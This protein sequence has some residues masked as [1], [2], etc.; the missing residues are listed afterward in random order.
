MCNA[1]KKKN[2]CCIIFS[3]TGHPM[4]VEHKCFYS[5]V[6]EIVFNEYV[7]SCYCTNSS[8]TNFCDYFFLRWHF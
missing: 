6:L 5:P 8:I 1:S 7:L 3:K 4:L 2:K